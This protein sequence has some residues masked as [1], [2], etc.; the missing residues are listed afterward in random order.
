MKLNPSNIQFLT[1]IAHQGKI[2]L[3]GLDQTT[4]KYCVKRDDEQAI[5]VKGYKL[6][7]EGL[8]ALRHELNTTAKL[9]IGTKL[10]DLV[11]QPVGLGFGRGHVVVAVGVR[12]NLFRGLAGVFGQDFVQLL[13]A[14][15]DLSRLDH[16]VGHRALGA[17]PGLVDHDA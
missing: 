2:V 9:D 8:A 6:T 1:D 16:D 12:C 13:L 15:L 5:R 10:D 14:A 11:D 7:S 17:A 3:F 4:V